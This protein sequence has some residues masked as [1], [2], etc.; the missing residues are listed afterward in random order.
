MGAGS[1]SQAHLVIWL[2]IYMCRLHLD[3]TVLQF[4]IWYG[5]ARQLASPQHQ[6]WPLFLA[7]QVLQRSEEPN[8]NG[9]SPKIIQHAM[10]PS[11]DGLSVL[12]QCLCHFNDGLQVTP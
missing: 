8:F 6:M 5:L 1:D 7:N 2:R 10:R 9:F 12:G 3:Q 4:V 11:A